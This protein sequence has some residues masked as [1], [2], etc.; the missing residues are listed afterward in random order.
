MHL[1]PR[2]LNTTHAL[3]LKPMHELH[4][5]LFIEPR[6]GPVFHMGEA[7]RASIAGFLAFHLLL[8]LNVS[9]LLI[10]GTKITKTTL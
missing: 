4:Q 9:L 10:P 8:C 7:L 6:L 1:M 2:I 5:L 3:R